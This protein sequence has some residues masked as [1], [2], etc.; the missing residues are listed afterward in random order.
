VAALL[1]VGITDTHMQEMHFGPILFREECV[2]KREI[3][4]SHPV[5]VHVRLSKARPDASRWSFRQEF[6]RADGTLCAVLTAEGAWIDMKLRKVTAP[7]A[8]LANGM[9]T[10]PR[11]DDFE[12]LA[13][14]EE[15]KA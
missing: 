7:P 11:T 12:M 4:M 14:P 1:A 6:V 2:F 13:M 10:L 9:L 5:E 8:E 3:R 15:K